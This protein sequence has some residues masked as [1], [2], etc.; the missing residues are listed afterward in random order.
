[1]ITLKKFER[2][3]L[4]KNP[5]AEGSVSKRGF[6]NTDFE[7]VPEIAFNHQEKNHQE[8]LLPLLMTKSVTVTEF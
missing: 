3:S 2:I 1:M 8:L 5:F 4:Y 7:K 6:Y